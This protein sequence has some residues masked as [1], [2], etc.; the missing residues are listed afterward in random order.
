MAQT[1]KNAVVRRTLR[2]YRVG[3]SHH[4]SKLTEEGVRTLRYRHEVLHEGY[5]KLAK[6]TSEHWS[7]PLHWSTIRDV[8]TY[9]TWP[10]VH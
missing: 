1:C 10:H 9:R 8:C 5:R 3:S 6:M 4:N 2:G 7:T